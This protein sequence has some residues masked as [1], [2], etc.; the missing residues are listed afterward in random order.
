MIM[1]QGKE[2]AATSGAKSASGVVVIYEDAATRQ[3]AVSFCDDLVERFW[4]RFHFEISWWSCSELQSARSS[5]N[6]AAK[7]IES[8]LVLL[9]TCPGKDLP[10]ELKDWIEGWVSQRTAGG[11]SLVALMDAGAVANGFA[12]QKYIYLRDVAHFAGMD[13]LTQM[14]QSISSRSI[15]DSLDSYNKRADKV[16]SVLDE[17][18]HRKAPPPPLLP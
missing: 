12:V 4:A 3:Q 16:T 15:P 5:R 13:Y 9:A 7:A 6:A 8:D 11:G 2:N 17:I 10:P 18:L 14:P 1:A